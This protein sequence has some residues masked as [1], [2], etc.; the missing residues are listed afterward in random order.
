MTTIM[1]WNNC[2]VFMT[3]ILLSKAL[4]LFLLMVF[5]PS[6]YFFSWTYASKRSHYFGT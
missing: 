6:W 1:K 5:Y 2:T 4:F 3:T